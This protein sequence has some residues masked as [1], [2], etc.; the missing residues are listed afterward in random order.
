MTSFSFFV[1]AR[2]REVLCSLLCYP[3]SPPAS[4][5]QAYQ[6]AGCCHMTPSTCLVVPDEMRML[7]ID[8]IRCLKLFAMMTVAVSG[9]G[10]ISG[11]WMFS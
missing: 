10:D 9:E 6:F 8:L 3:R 4:Y 5:L 1:L 2:G 7:W 11:H